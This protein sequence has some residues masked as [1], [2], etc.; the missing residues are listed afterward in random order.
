MLLHACVLLHFHER[1]TAED[2]RV[3]VYWCASFPPRGMAPDGLKTM[4]NPSDPLIILSDSI[5]S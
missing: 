3:C 4:N 5:S 1:L 2:V